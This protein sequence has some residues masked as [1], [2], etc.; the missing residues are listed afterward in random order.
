MQEISEKLKLM[1]KLWQQGTIITTTRCLSNI[2]FDDNTHSWMIHAKFPQSWTNSPPFFAVKFL[3]VLS[4]ER[5][6]SI[7]RTIK[8]PLY[9]GHWMEWRKLAEASHKLPRT[10]SPRNW[11]RRKDNWRGKNC[12]RFMHM[13]SILTQYQVPSTNQY[14]P[15]LTQHHHVQVPSSAALY[16]PST[17]KYQPILPY[18]DLVPPSPITI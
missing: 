5:T 1:H 13:G 7:P 14:W 17:T 4:R 2:Y 8:R 11:R 10:L 15:L 16:W 18:N 3:F 12:W 9:G 6:I